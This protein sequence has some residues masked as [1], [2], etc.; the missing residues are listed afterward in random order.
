MAA[1]AGFFA[2]GLAFGAPVG[3]T[4]VALAAAAFAVCGL[5]RPRR[6]FAVGLV[7]AGFAPAGFGFA[8]AAGFAAGFGFATAAGLEG[9]GFATA[10]A[11]GFGLAAALGFGAAGFLAAA[12]GAAALAFGAAG[13]GFAGFGA[14]G[15]FA[16]VLGLALAFGAGSA[17]PALAVDARPEGFGVFTARGLALRGRRLRR[18]GG[19]RLRRADV[20][21]RRGRRRIGRGRR[22]GGVVLAAQESFRHLDG[23]ASGLDGRLE[24]FLL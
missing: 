16:A 22:D 12:F 24:Q 17:G 11:F 19:A 7:A 13:F 14:A 18:G 2:A 6:A 1:A 4:S 21:G 9:A 5:R 10:V 3:T 15:F 23:L 20:L 8:T